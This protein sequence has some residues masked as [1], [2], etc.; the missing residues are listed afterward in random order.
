MALNNEVNSKRHGSLI[1]QCSANVSGCLDEHTCLLT[2]ASNTVQAANAVAI[3]ATAGPVAAPAIGP[4]AGPPAAPAAEPEQAA[5]N[6]VRRSQRP[7]HVSKQLQVN[8]CTL[9][10]NQAAASAARCVSGTLQPCLPASDV[11]MSLRQVVCNV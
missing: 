2:C 4:P 5:A 7:R 6:N 1:T 9:S 10:Y 3:A 11:G 8:I